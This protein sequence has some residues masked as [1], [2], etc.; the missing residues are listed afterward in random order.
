LTEIDIKDLLK[1]EHHMSAD[2]YIVARQ[3]FIEIRD[4]LS[5]FGDFL[6]TVGRALRDKPNQ[7]VFSNTPRGLMIEEGAAPMP[8]DA[9][10][11]KTPEEIAV[12]LKEYKDAKAEMH[13]E[14]S[15]IPQNVRG[16]V[17]APQ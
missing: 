4:Q 3:R 5:K 15:L 11:W 6:Q 13:K 7:M 17:I 12:M 2:T 8:I 1:K 16:G 10:R 9:N 14:Y